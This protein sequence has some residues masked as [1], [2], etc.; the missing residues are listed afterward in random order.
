VKAVKTYNL[1]SSNS[2]TG[3][4][5]QGN[6]TIVKQAYGFYNDEINKWYKINTSNGYK[7]VLQESMNNTP[8]YL[9]AK[10]DIRFYTASS[11]SLSDIR[12]TQVYQ[13]GMTK[14]TDNFINSFLSVSAKPSVYV[15]DNFN[16]GSTGNLITRSKFTSFDVNVKLYKYKKLV[17][18]SIGQYNLYLMVKLSDLPN[19]SNVTKYELINSNPWRITKSILSY[20]TGNITV[21][22]VVYKPLMTKTLVTYNANQNDQ[23]TVVA[24]TGVTMT[25]VN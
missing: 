25:T 20:S 2:P 12:N 5:I 6:Y 7:W 14:P 4:T 22:G 21:S 10:N 16:T 3:S 15:F 17:D 9:S 23:F 11:M 1:P 24:P 8:L 18:A 19:G 13:A